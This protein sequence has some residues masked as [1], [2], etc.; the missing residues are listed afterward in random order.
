MRTKFVKTQ[1]VLRMLGSLGE[2]EKRSAVVPGLAL[3][4]GHQGFGKT[5]ATHWYAVQHNCVYLRAQGAW[6]VNWL[7]MDLAA[8]LGLAPEGVSRQNFRSIKHELYARP[9]LVLLDEA[10]Y[11]IR[12]REL[13]DTVRDMHDTS[14]AP[15]CLVG[16][17]G[18]R[19]AVARKSPQFWSRVSQEV[20]FGPLTLE[21]VAVIAAELAGITLT[22]EHSREIRRRTEGNFRKTVVVLAKIETICK[23]NRTEVS[24][25]VIDLAGKGLAIN[26]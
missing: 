13:L 1:N 18:A 9:R 6:T 21:D 19:E 7:L 22:P 15:V 14:G 17:A 4:H 8:S 25:Q 16:M 20:E 5:M 11:V 12:R 3:I 24:A 26:E 10:D 23:T 2:L